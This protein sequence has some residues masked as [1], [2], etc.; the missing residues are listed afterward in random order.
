MNVSYT[1]FFLEEANLI[2]FRKCF[3]D[4]SY[5]PENNFDVY[6]GE[7]ENIFNYL[8]NTY[9]SQI[10]KSINEHTCTNVKQRL[11]EGIKIPQMVFE[12]FGFTPFMLYGEAEKKHFKSENLEDHSNYR[13]LKKKCF[14]ALLGCFLYYVDR[15][16]FP[17]ISCT[18]LYHFIKPYFAKIE[19]REMENPY[20]TLKN[21]YDRHQRKLGGNLKEMTTVIQTKIGDIPYHTVQIKVVDAHKNS[22]IIAEATEKLVDD[23]KREASRIALKYF[24]IS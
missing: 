3:I 18:L 16:T 2:E 7:G 1:N 21:Y 4:Q 6:I 10:T 17:G 8:V 23:A 22:K 20:S 9:I 14:K 19:I 15:K 5:S 12:D 13:K 24:R 11:S